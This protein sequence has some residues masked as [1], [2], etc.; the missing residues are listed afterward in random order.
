MRKPPLFVY[1]SFLFFILLSGCGE[2]V[3]LWTEQVNL[4]GD[5]TL[6]RNVAREFEIRFDHPQPELNTRLEFEVTYDV[7][8]IGQDVLPLAI[9]VER[10]DSVSKSYP[11]EYT[12]S[13]PLKK[14]GNWQG[15]ASGNQV[16]NSLTFTVI[17]ELILKSNTP[18][19]LKVYA[20][21]SDA[22]YGI[23]KIAARLYE[24][25]PPEEADEDL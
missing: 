1:P 19:V 5:Y 2:I 23:V 18:Y 7:S 4:S 22:I 15:Q 21:E 13:V 9:F 12:F 24:N 14:D 10:K 25:A 17:P 3:P 20:N 8:S 6:Y 11:T 16:D